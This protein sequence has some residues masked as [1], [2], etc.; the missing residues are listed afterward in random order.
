MEIWR[1]CLCKDVQVH[2][3]YRKLIPEDPQVMHDHSDFETKV[4]QEG[5]RHAMKRGESDHGKLQ[6]PFESC[7]SLT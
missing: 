1:L 6:G 7:R 4:W 3:P 2:G 5:S